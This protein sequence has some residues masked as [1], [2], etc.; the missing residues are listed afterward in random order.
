[1]LEYRYRPERLRSP[2]PPSLVAGAK[3]RLR[4]FLHLRLLGTGKRSREFLRVLADTGSADV[5][6]PADAATAVGAQLLPSSGHSLVWHGTAF[7]LRFAKVELELLTATARCRWPA[8]AAFTS[9]Q[10]PYPLFGMAGGLEYFDTT[11]RGEDERVELFPNGR[12][13]GTVT[14]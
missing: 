11:F 7:P 9:A 5:V 13:P 10:L 4:P 3:Y 1:M 12:F 6:F 14:I 8:V 2:A